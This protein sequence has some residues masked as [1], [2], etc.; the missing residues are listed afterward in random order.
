MYNSQEVDIG[1]DT[2]YHHY[3][4]H[5][6]FRNATLVVPGIVS[7]VSLII[8]INISYSNLLFPSMLSSLIYSEKKS[9]VTFTI[10]P[11]V[12]ARASV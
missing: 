11:M 8:Y 2:D 1:N 5:A 6:P 10:I 7:I 9:R 12:T 3:D 4:F